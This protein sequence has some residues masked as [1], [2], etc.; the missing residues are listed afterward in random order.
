MRNTHF[1]ENAKTGLTGL[2]IVGIAGTTYAFLS[3][4]VVM[5]TALLA[6]LVGSSTPTGTAV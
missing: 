2:A 3:F 4:A 5:A 6:L 1:L